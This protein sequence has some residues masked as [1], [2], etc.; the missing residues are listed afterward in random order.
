VAT[1]SAYP[2]YYGYGTPAG[3]GVESRQ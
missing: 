3:S 1:M 2:A